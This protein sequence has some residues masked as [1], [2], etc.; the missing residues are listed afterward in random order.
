MDIDKV[1]FCAVLETNI[2][3]RTRLE[4]FF[5]Y[6]LISQHRSSLAATDEKITIFYMLIGLSRPRQGE[7]FKEEFLQGPWPAYGL[8]DSLYE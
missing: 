4:G 8:H 1:R 5:F 2:R 7:D 3:S 6:I